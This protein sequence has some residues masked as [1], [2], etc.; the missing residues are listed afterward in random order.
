MGKAPR[1]T[2]L[3]MAEANGLIYSSLATK[4][5]ELRGGRKH[6]GGRAA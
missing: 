4:V 1:G 3:R 2:L 5:Y 6:R